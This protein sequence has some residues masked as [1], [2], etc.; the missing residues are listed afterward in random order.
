MKNKFIR[1][2][3]IAQVGDDEEEEK[4]AVGFSEGSKKKKRRKKAA[5]AVT[6]ILLPIDT[7][8]SIIK[9]DDETVII[10]TLDKTLQAIADFNV[11][12]KKLKAI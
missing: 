6:S 3:I 1:L 4:Q 12:S 2:Q 5:A 9:A 7:I 8:T 11:L 10:D